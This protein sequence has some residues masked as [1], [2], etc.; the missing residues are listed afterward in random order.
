MSSANAFNSDKYELLLLIIKN[1]TQ[2][3]PYN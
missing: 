2:H 1:V 3:L